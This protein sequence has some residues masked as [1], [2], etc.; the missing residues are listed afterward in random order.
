MMPRGWRTH[1]DPAPKLPPE[2]AAQ[3]DKYVNTIGNLRW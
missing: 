1:W 3:R 2:D